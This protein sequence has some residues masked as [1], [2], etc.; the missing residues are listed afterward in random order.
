MTAI[1]TLKPPRFAD[2]VDLDIHGE[3]YLQPDELHS[4][5]RKAT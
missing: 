3:D 5:G 4:L 2:R 1:E